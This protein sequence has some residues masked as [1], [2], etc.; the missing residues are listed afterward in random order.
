M[1]CPACAEGADHFRKFSNA[2]VAAAYHGVCA[3]DCDC[4]HKIGQRSD[5]TRVGVDRYWEKERA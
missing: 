3:G 1:I 4:Q 5:F 2:N